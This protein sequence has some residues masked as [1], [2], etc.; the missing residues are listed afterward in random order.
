MN[1]TVRHIEETLFKEFSK[2]KVYK[3]S[4]R[5]LSEATKF[6]RSTIYYYFDD[7]NH[8]YKSVF[9]DFILEEIVRDCNSIEEFVK[10]T[11]N[12]I[13]THKNLCLNLYY[14]TATPRC[15]QDAINVLNEILPKL[16]V[17]PNGHNSMT[18]Y[19]LTVDDWFK[20][21]LSRSKDDL[22]NELLRRL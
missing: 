3:Y 6:H 14:L 18:D 1:L 15:H 10:R 9:E 5:E 20:G 7:I 4:I 13:A 22:I 8:I 16:R 21:N 2:R 19:I 17:D 12:Y 11:I